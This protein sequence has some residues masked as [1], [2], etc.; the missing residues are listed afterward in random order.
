MLSADAGMTNSSRLEATG[1]QMDRE[2]E[3]RLAAQQAIR[4]VEDGSIVGVGTGSTVAHFIDELGK[5]RSRIEAAV[6]SSDKSTALLQQAGI[7]VLDLNS[8][9][10][11]KLYVDGA[12]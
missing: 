12:D 1:G 7:R 9:G 8:A 11:L 4:Y 3:K 10:E 5:I 6:S 2:A